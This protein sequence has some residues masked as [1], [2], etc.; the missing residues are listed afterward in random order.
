MSGHKGRR[1]AG[2]LMAVIVIGATALSPLPALAAPA[3]ARAFGMSGQSSAASSAGSLTPDAS[4]ALGGG[5]SSFAGIEMNQWTD[6]VSSLNPPIEISY[7]PSSSGTGRQYFRSGNYPYAVSDIAFQGS[8]AEDLP[9]NFPFDYIPIVAGGLGFMYNLPNKPAIKLTAAVACGIFTGEIT[10]WDDPALASLNPGVIL[11]NVA[12]AVVLRGD[13]AGTSWVLSDW[14]LTQAP[15]VW[16]SFVS[17][18]NSHGENTGTPPVNDTSPSSDFPVVGGDETAQGDSGTA[19]VVSSTPGSITYVEPEYAVEYGNMPVASVQN[20][21]G[22]FVQPTPEN[23]AG[24]LAYAQGQ[25]NGIQQLNFAGTGCNVYNP[26]TYSYMLVRT[27][28]NYG[29]TYGQ[30]VGGFLNYVLTIGERNAPQINYADIGLSL[31]QYGIGRAQLV[32]GYPA[33]TSS[34]QANFA[35]GDVTPTIAQQTPCGQAFQLAPV[36]TTQAPTTTS[37][38]TTTVATTTTTVATTTTRPATTTTVH[39]TTTVPSSAGSPTTVSRAT[40]TTRATTPNTRVTVT[41][42]TT[43]TTNRSSPAASSTT[44]TT[45]GLGRRTS[46]TLPVPTTNRTTGTRPGASRGGKTPAGKTRAG[47][48]PAGKTPAGTTPAGTTPGGTTPGGTTPGTATTGAP[49]PGTGT[50][51][52]GTPSTG[53]PGTGTPGVS[54]SVPAAGGGVTTI[55]IGTTLPTG[56][57]TGTTASTGSPTTASATEPQTKASSSASVTGTPTAGAGAGTPTTVSPT[58]SLS[59][60]SPGDAQTGGQQVF[61]VVAGLGIAALSELTRRRLRRAR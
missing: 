5:G 37:T 22:D 3:H 35:A 48:T 7:T 38:T 60:G 46:P 43:A 57:V 56:G 23:V 34:E 42:G 24:A 30:T 18:L 19:A 4:S 45:V 25:P 8:V 51:S 26:S 50:P 17:Y 36:S 54:T 53:T 40:S 59:G 61:L 33:L 13:L 41:T 21:S 15:Q 32:P 44:V 29:S 58:V 14:C 52:T 12:I 31:E 1:R 20:A 16:Q 11:P 9:P 27:D 49:T 55:E 2:I 6:D 39:A 47:K 28:G 10:N